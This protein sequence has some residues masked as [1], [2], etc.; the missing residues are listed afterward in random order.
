MLLMGS[1]KAF[2]KQISKRWDL[3][4][5]PSILVFTQGVNTI[6]VNGRQTDTRLALTLSA[7]FL[8]F[9]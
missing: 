3:L 2:Y 5:N 6:A 8:V 7:P 1:P 9:L 4:A